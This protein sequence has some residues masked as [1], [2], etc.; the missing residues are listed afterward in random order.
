MSTQRAWAVGLHFWTPATF[1]SEE[2][3]SSE[4]VGAAWGSGLSLLFQAT[5]T[6]RTL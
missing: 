6:H 4:C 2:K 1:G 5:R 3:M